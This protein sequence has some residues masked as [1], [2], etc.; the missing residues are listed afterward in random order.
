MF[1]HGNMYLV[2]T[3]SALDSGP[4]DF[5]FFS[6]LMYAALLRYW[7]IT[8]VLSDL[9]PPVSISIRSHNTIFL[10]DCIAQNYTWNK[11]VRNNDWFRYVHFGFAG[12]RVLGGMDVTEPRAGREKCTYSRYHFCVPSPHTKWSTRCYNTW[13]VGMQGNEANPWWMSVQVDQQKIDN[14]ISVEWATETQQLSINDA[15]RKRRKKGGGG[16]H[17]DRMIEHKIK[18]R[19]KTLMLSTMAS[20]LQLKKYF[21]GKENIAI[22]PRNP[23][24]TALIHSRFAYPALDV[25]PNLSGLLTAL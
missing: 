21:K 18:K 13:R 3:Y 24:H 7:Y 22:G 12:S 19:E 4:L 25:H 14:G 5:C 11:C 23:S 10:W 9:W 2:S 1:A 8:K 20:I 15:Q 6:T 16:Y 17:G